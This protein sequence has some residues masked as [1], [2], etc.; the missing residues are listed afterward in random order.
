[1]LWSALRTPGI[2]TPRLGPPEKGGGSSRHREV[3]GRILSHTLHNSQPQQQ[4][5]P[6]NNSTG[7]YT[8]PYSSHNTPHQYYTWSDVLD[9]SRPNANS[10]NGPL[11][12]AAPSALSADL[13]TAPPQIPPPPSVSPVFTCLWSRQIEAGN[14][15][16]NRTEQTQ[17]MQRQ[18]MQQLQNSKH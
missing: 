10:P 12:M 14:E 16:P 13:L 15:G 9:S 8:A 7:Y 3:E 18:Q 4:Q 11:G 1:V 6:C 17:K 2:L 5:Q